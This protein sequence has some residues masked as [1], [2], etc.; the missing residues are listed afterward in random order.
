VDDVAH[1]MMLCMQKSPTNQIINIGSGRPHKFLDMVNRAI[2]YSNSK[3]KI[4]HI[5]P[6][7]FHDIVQVRHSYLDT[8]KI[9]S[10]GFKQKKDISTI[11]EELVDHYKEEEQKQ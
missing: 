5:D 8:S 7:P 9:S 2:D 6:T 11:I 4:I 1:A 3:S 10:Y